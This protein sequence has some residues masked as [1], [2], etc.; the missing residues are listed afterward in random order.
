M[1][2]NL[3]LSSKGFMGPIDPNF[4][5]PVQGGNTLTSAG[6]LFAAMPIG[7]MIT[8]YTKGGAGGFVSGVV[9]TA[10]A[11]AVS[12]AVA[13]GTAAGAMTGGTA[14]LAAI[15][16]WGWAAMAG[17]ALLGGSKG[18]YVK[19]TGESG[20]SFDAAG[21]VVSTDAYRYAVDNSNADKVVEAMN[22]TYLDAARKLGIDTKASSFYYGSNDSNGGRMAV[23]AT[24]GGKDVYNS[25]EVASG[26]GEA[27]LAASQ[28][29]LSALQGSD[30]PKYL[31]GIFDG[32]DATKLKQADIDTLMNS[33]A[34][35]KDLHDTLDK[36]PFAELKDAS[37][38]TMT[39]LADAVK[40]YQR[41]GETLPQTVARL[42]TGF[43][44]VNDAFETM[45]LKMYD[46]SVKGAAAAQGL[47]D[48]AG[49]LDVLMGQLQS[50]YQNFYTQAERD[51]GTYK[52]LS[53]IAGQNG[54]QVTPEQLAGYTKDQ[55]RAF[56]DEASKD[57][58]ESGKKLFALLLKYQNDWFSVHERGVT[59]AGSVYPTSASSAAR[60]LVSA[61]QKASEAQAAIDR[62]IADNAAAAA[63]A[64][65]SALQEAV[66][67][68]AGATA[69]I[70]QW[71]NKLNTTD[72]GGL[73]PEQQ[74]ANSWASLQSQ[75]VLA[76]G[77]SRDAM[78]GITGYADT[79]IAAIKAT[80]KSA[81]EE[82]SAISRVKAQ[83]GNLPSQVSAEQFIVNALN[84]NLGNQGDIAQ[85]LEELKTAKII[86]DLTVNAISEITKLIKYVTD[87]D[88]LPA[89]LKALALAES[90]EMLKTIKLVSDTSVLTAGE[91]IAILEGSSEAT[92]LVNLALGSDLPDEYKRLA[93]NTYD[94]ILK[95]VNFAVTD[96]ADP[97]Q[98]ALALSTTGSVLKTISAAAGVM[99]ANALLV[100][101]AQS[102]TINKLVTASGGVLTAD[103]QLL[104]NNV[105]SYNKTIQLLISGD[106]S[107]TVESFMQAHFG[108]K[109]VDVVVNMLGGDA[110]SL[111]SGY[112][113]DLLGKVRAGTMTE[114]SAVAQAYTAAARYHVTQQQIADSTGYSLPDVQAMFDRYNIPRFAVGTD[115]VP[116]DMLAMIHQGEQIVPKAYNPHA[117]GMG[118]GGGQNLQALQQE[119]AM[120]RA[121]ARASQIQMASLMARLTKTHERWDADGL[122]TTRVET[123]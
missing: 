86:A 120:L 80:S 24:V 4:M 23:G 67:Y 102:A 118:G 115:L 68:L 91:K 117:N 87:T 97:T 12:G 71:L 52:N 77:G 70:G 60:D 89:D 47:I 75:L 6:D 42:G 96:I 27:K 14:A 1:G 20:K 95:T 15:P 62:Q 43:V 40:E 83:V 37:Y 8:A 123:A 73:S 38:A 69:N 72:A 79:Y 121:D 116:R 66:D 81:A 76:Q 44:M 39:G 31:Q 108:T 90:S 48:T 33:A 58:S 25:G 21:R 46:V 114:G 74:R 59:G 32:V 45:G 30:L 113:N 82:Q 104:L 85:R 64:Q 9:G 109:T 26:E 13:T 84:E 11:G 106:S 54:Y 119:I 94:N 28:A 18:T 34:G 105:S 65:A 103:Q 36:L 107:N 3:G 111:V 16:G 49:G 41:A 98:R 53:N 5:G 17:L 55:V 22:A 10:T 63:A 100:A 35:F 110:N 92:R 101:A 19:S 2:Q 112:V 93:L 61:Q 88:L 99:D 78:S 50:Y 122:P 56:I 51:Q 57:Q 29:V 7:G